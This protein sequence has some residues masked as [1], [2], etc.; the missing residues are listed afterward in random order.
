MRWLQNAALGVLLA[1]GLWS[2]IGQPHPANAAEVAFGP[3]ANTSDGES[4]T[5][6]LTTLGLLLAAAA[7]GVLR[8]RLRRDPPKPPMPMPPWPP[9]PGGPSNN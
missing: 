1:G 5:A 7:V 9:G 6:P 3:G 2:W 4:W 8:Q